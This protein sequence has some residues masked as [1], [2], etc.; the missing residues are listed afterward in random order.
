MN[1]LNKP[2]IGKYGIRTMNLFIYESLLM[3]HAKRD[4]FI[5]RFYRNIESDSYS[6]IC[7][8]NNI[9]IKDSFCKEL[10]IRIY[11]IKL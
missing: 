8:I 4:Y 10:S 7:D 6:Y 2:S 9:W 5:E 3:Y 1:I 11:K